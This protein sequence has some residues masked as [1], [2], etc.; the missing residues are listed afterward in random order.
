MHPDERDE[1]DDGRGR[2]VG[3]S[4]QLRALFA[5]LADVGCDRDKALHM[6]HPINPSTILM[7]P[8]LALYLDLKP[9][10]VR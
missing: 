8:R 6:I 4:I 10:L 1:E 2:Q 3:I 5:S 9:H 7:R